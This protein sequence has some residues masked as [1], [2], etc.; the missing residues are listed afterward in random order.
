MYVHAYQSYIW[1]LITSERIKLSS[2]KPLEGDMIIIKEGSDNTLTSNDDK[3]S[4]PAL[5]H[6]SSA[7]VKYLTKEDLDKYTIFDIVH[8]LP[9]FDVEYP[10]GRIGDLYKE[11]LKADGLDLDHMR[12]DQRLVTLLHSSH[13]DN[14]PVLPFGS[15][16]WDSISLFNK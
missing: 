2:T 8:P 16:V 1:N 13:I 15:R 14:S 10:K 4:R 12:R 7:T 5:E 6:S 11:L 3:S 9:G